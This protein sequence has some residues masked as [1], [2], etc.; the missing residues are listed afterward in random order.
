MKNKR[1][2]NC[3]IKNLSPSKA[4]MF[5]YGEIVATDTKREDYEDVTPLMAKEF[6]E[7]AG[8]RELD[9]YINSIGGDV[10]S[11][12]AIYNMLKSYPAKKNVFVEG[13]AG[14]IASV[15][16]MAGD[17]IN[18]PVNAHLMIH[19]AWCEVVGDSVSLQKVIESL[20]RLDNIIADIYMSK[21]IDSS[22]TK[23]KILELME[24]ETWLNGAEA[25]KIF[26]I[27]ATAENK[28]A[29]KVKDLEK[30]QLKNIPEDIKNKK[31]EKVEL[32]KARLNLLLTIGDE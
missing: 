19:K 23:E 7:Y 11:G 21:V 27:T 26:N 8:N 25:E 29:A 15:I 4:E 5:I 10:Y 30:F 14:S 13:V 3:E 1:F 12:I 17:E 22:I 24:N 31:L 28:I 18:I 2:G 32:E 16:A 20:L 6:L 9:I